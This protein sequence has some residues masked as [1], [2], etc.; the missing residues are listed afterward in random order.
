MSPWRT[1][2][3]VRAVTGAGLLWLAVVADARGQLATVGGGVL[4]SERPS[5]TVAELHAE[6]A[7]LWETR[8]Y[9]TLSWTQH[10]ARPTGI[11]A[12]E[13]TVA[14]VGQ[15]MVRLGAGMLWLD[16]NDYRPYPILVS[17]SIVPLPVPQTALIVIA[18]TQPFQRL[19]WSL[20]FKVGVTV[21]FRS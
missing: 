1:L 6:T 12:A 19:D 9:I 16:A 7:P 4:V 17:S 18:S 21:W 5:E 14:T 8:G 15:S 2:L 20:V 10:S 3:A 11:T 13:R